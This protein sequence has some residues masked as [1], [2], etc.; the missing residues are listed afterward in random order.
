MPARTL[1]DF[2][3]G[4]FYGEIKADLETGML[5]R[6]TYECQKNGDMTII[7]VEGASDKGKRVAVY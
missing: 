5:I 6:Y 4:F 1:N 3:A 7:N 2:A